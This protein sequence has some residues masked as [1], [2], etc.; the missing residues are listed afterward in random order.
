MH[1]PDAQVGGPRNPAMFET[2]ET[3][4]LMSVSL[5]AASHVLTVSGTAADDVLTADAQG[6][7]LVVHDN[8]AVKAFPLSAVK[9]IVV[10]GGDGADK[11][12][13]WPTVKLP[14]VL[15]TGP[16]AN[17]AVQGGGGR[18]QIYVESPASDAY[19]GDGNDVIY[20]G[21]DTSGDN[22]LFGQ[23]GDDRFVM[24]NA[25]GLIW[26]DGGLGVDT[27]DFSAET[28]GLLLQNGWAGEYDLYRNVPV[29]NDQAGHLAGF[30]NFVG[31]KGNDYLHGDAANN[32]L[33]GNA[34]ND[35][36]YG[37]AGDDLLNGGA[38]IDRLYGEAGNDTLQ[39]KDWAAEVL[40]GGT[41]TDTA[42]ADVSDLVTGV[43]VVVP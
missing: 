40:D 29:P 10:D 32:I 22:D 37:G 3:R 8:A 15:R 25:G 27:A 23:A 31:G 18:D 6:A 11:I 5:N 20:G 1:R 26:C 12:V 38:G 34:G 14:T 24:K 42:Q 2:L 41:G 30:E 35:R 17:D 7:S 13:V 39:G 21:L 16:G 4:R 36:L 43:E 33:W 9:S 28:D 19:G